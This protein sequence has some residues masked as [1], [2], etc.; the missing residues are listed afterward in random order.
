VTNDVFHDDSRTSFREESTSGIYMH[1]QRELEGTVQ[2]IVNYT[3]APKSLT[4]MTSSLEF[5]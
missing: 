5:V 1:V 4:Q 2:A 3:N